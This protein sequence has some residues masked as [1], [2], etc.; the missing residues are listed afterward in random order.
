MVSAVRCREG[1]GVY[2]RVVVNAVSY[3]EEYAGLGILPK[4]Y[5]N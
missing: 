1:G 5:A 2:L 3:F 4:Q